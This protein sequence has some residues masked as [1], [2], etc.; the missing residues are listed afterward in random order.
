M[1]VL[2]NM[3]ERCMRHAPH[4]KH[5][6]LHAP[7]SVG[8]DGLLLPHETPKVHIKKEQVSNWTI[9]PG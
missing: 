1:H 5:G 3:H 8:F 6:K 7:L 2:V 9:Q 4:F